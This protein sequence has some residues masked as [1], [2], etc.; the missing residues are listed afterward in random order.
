VE[1]QYEHGMFFLSSNM[2][3]LDKLA[4]LLL[5]KEKV[6]GDELM[7][8]INV[9]AAEGKLALGQEQKRRG[10]A[11]R[12]TGVHAGQEPSRFGGAAHP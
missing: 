11:R 2:Y 3:V 1:K 5:E 4:D 8:L 12:R 10:R 6:N 9:A 7:R